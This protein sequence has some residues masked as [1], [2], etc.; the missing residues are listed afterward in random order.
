MS[1]L[2]SMVAM[3]MSF[4]KPLMAEK[5][6][7]RT[8]RIAAAALR[9]IPAIEDYDSLTQNIVEQSLVRLMFNAQWAFA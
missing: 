6:I 9:K 4:S 3:T 7:L 8:S 5:L 2:A 1:I